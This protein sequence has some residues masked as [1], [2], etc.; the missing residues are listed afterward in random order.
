MATGLST[1]A[2]MREYE[3]EMLKR[4]YGE[5]IKWGEVDKAE[6]I[7]KALR[8]IQVAQQPKMPP[9]IKPQPYRDPFAEPSSLSD[10]YHHDRPHYPKFEDLNDSSSVHNMDIEGVKNLWTAR[11]GSGWVEDSATAEALQ[12]NKYFWEQVFFRL[13]P[14]FEKQQ[15]AVSDFALAWAW[16]LKEDH[17]NN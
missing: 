1:Q 14:H 9:N 8:R 4:E 5:A 17:G 15:Y 6:K 7:M 12:Q 16:R 10:S 2:S 11:F 13:R 3:E